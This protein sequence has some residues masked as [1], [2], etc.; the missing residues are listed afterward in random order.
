MAKKK[1]QTVNPEDGV[2]NLFRVTGG[3]KRGQYMNLEDAQKEFEKR[4]RALIKKEE[5]FSLKLYG[6]IKV[7]G[8][9][10]EWE[11]LR[12]VTYSDDSFED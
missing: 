11:L 3:G 6:A 4:E 9:K 1:A 8:E 12:E 5:G 7:I 10:T 2:F